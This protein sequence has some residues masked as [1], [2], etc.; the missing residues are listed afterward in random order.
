MHDRM[1]CLFIRYNAA[2][3]LAIRA[4]VRWPSTHHYI[5]NNCFVACHS[6]SRDGT[7]LKHNMRMS[8][9][10]C[11]VGI[12]YPTHSCKIEQ[13]QLTW[14][15]L[16]MSRVFNFLFSSDGTS[17]AFGAM[18]G[19]YICTQLEYI[20]KHAEVRLPTLHARNR[21]THSTHARCHSSINEC[22][23][24]RTMVLLNDQWHVVASASSLITCSITYFVA[25]CAHLASY[26]SRIHY[27]HYIHYSILYFS[28]YISKF[29]VGRGLLAPP[30]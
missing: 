15:L 29:S 24:Q 9:M 27:N 5:E 26:I 25:V 22:Q 16:L 13:S 23:W 11:V 20:K 21:S 2:R 6:F 28:Q 8:S 19:S 30:K 17:R 18:H 4:D 3:R 1:V 12:K 14:H 7:R 10:S